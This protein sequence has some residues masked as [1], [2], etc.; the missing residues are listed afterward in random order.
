MRAR[1]EVN[2]INAQGAI[3]VAVELLLPGREILIQCERPRAN[4]DAALTDAFGV[5]EGALA[6]HA[7]LY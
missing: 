7:T 4:M 6:R 1:V 3:D 2:R 5:A